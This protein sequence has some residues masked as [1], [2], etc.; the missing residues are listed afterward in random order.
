MPLASIIINNFNYGR[1]IGDAIESA[2]AQ[3]YANNEVIIVD[4]GSTDNSREIIA[5]Y[6]NRVQCVFKANGGQGSALN[7]GFAAS[8]G[9]FVFFLD[10]DDVL[11]PDAVSN[12]IQEFEAAPSRLAKVQWPLW[13]VDEN[14][15]RR[16]DTKPPQPPPQGDF[17]DA[18]L[19]GGPTSCIS[20]PTS[21]NAWARWYLNLVMPIPEDVPYYRL[22]ADEYLYTLAPV[23][24]PVR[25]IARPQGLYRIHGNNVY[26]SLTFEKRLKLELDGH[27]QQS[28]ALAKVLRR[29]GIE[30][31]LQQWR[32]R[33]WFHR[34]KW[35]IEQLR[36]LLPPNGELVL[37][38]DDTLD[39]KHALGPMRVTLFNERDGKY[40]GA[41]T[42]DAS[43]IAELN[44]L[45][46]IGAT[47]LA[48]VWPA[49][50]WIEHY[51]KLFTEL[52][53]TSCCVLRDPRMTVYDLRS[54]TGA[55]ADV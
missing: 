43:A 33:S 22:C 31:D 24:G 39:A 11:F 26:S 48:I 44:R 3:T 25:T 32:D 15:N 46:S 4:D 29:H 18:V 13:I 5:S 38:D 41:P 10:S 52:E 50:W 17:R 7:A 36:Q 53:S 16:G 47:H 35:S 6:A 1:F 30:V 55:E 45:R 28:Q 27:E 12:V 21:G 9:D 54:P 40:W 20:S 23:F 49:L 37:I 2:L 42:D 19:A 14:G 51:S 8:R 34:L